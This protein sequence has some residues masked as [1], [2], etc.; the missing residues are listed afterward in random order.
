MWENMCNTNDRQL[1]ATLVWKELCSHWE[2]IIIPPKG[3][4][5]GSSADR[6]FLL[7]LLTCSHRLWRC[8]ERDDQWQFLSLTPVRIVPAPF[9]HTHTHTHH[10]NIIHTYTT[11]Y[12]H[13]HIQQTTHMQPCTIH[14]HHTNIAYTHAPHN[15]TCVHTRQAT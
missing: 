8:R 9:A 6:I 10:V 3:K 13:V 4:S 5:I 15:N 1:A 14:T 12:R 11:Q 7:S 2:N